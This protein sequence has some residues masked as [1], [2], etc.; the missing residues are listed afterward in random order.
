MKT[1]FVYILASKRNG[2]LY[3]GMTSDLVAR[4]Y[5]HKHKLVEGFTADF[6]VDRLVWYESTTDVYAA[7]T[8]ERQIKKWRREWKLKVIEEVNPDWKDLS[9]DD[10]E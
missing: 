8:K 9:L 6:G 5:Q 1:Y 3:V 10:L 4:V 2:T 7:I